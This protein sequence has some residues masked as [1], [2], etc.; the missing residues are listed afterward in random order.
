MRVFRILVAL[1]MLCAFAGVAQA[2]S[3]LALKD[4]ELVGEVN[5][6]AIKVTSEDMRWGDVGNAPLQYVA[7]GGDAAEKA[8][9]KPSLMLFD[10]SGRFLRGYAFE[11]AEECA[12][13]TLSPDG[14]IIGV[15]T[16]GANVE[17]WSFRTAADFKPIL[18]ETMDLFAPEDKK[19]VNWAGDS[20]A[21]VHTFADQSETRKCESELCISTSVEMV[22][23]QT[24]KITPIFAGTELCDYVFV[25]FEGGVVT[26]EAICLPKAEDWKNEEAEKSVKEVTK[27]LQ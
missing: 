5:G 3:S 4:E 20:L 27:K 26:G 23:L 21:F 18:E 8:G 6:K 13:V 22:D 15:A 11:D 14:K 12:G 9:L 24:K 16:G 10:E 19:A 25:S 7:L 17:I 2:A 1:A